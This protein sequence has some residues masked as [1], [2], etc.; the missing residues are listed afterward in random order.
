MKTLVRSAIMFLMCTPA[1]AQWTKVPA[2]AIPRTP[3]GKPNLSAP[4]PRLPD[5]KPDLSGIWEP[6]GGYVAN[7]ALDLKPEEVPFRPWA[8]A[9]Y[10]E[11]KDGSHS[12]ED[13]PAHCLP[14]SVPRINA[15]PAPW[16]I[17]QTPGFVAILYE[18]FGIW[19]QIFTDGRELLP[20]F[21]P[22]WMGYSTARW[23]GDTLVV[24]T[25]GFNGK[26]WLDQLGKPSTDAL[27][28]IERFRRKDFGHI[29][30]QIT[31]DDPKAY[32]RPWTVTEEVHLLTDTE[33]MEFV[34]LEN[35]VDLEHL[36]GK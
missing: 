19:R 22:T 35:N 21:T 9:L 29:D 24:D 28:V 33:L 23:D 13:P 30:I 31:I 32:T 20:D 3:D 7:L 34:C 15:A 17:I 14:Q 6:K 26:A 11:R 4:A 1:W 2:A 8:G 5:G 10:N 27:H 12:R 25:G 36:P 16:K 18:A